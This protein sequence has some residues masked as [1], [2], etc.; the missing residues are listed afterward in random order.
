M[1]TKEY[2]GAIMILIG[3]FGLACYGFMYPVNSAEP[4]KMY[5]SENISTAVST[6]LVKTPEG[7]YRIFIYSSYKQGGITAVKIK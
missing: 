4:V 6:S 1:S 7:L 5:S 2:L 3:A